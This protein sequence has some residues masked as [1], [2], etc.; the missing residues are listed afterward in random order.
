MK[1]DGNGKVLNGAIVLYI[2][3]LLLALFAQQF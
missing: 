2:N 1:N 3:S